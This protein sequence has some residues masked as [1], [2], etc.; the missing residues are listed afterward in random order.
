MRTPVAS[1]CC[2]LKREAQRLRGRRAVTE[3]DA[4]EG[5]GPHVGRRHVSDAVVVEGQLR[6]VRQGQETI[7]PVVQLR[8]V[9]TQRRYLELRARKDGIPVCH[10]DGGTAAHLPGAAVHLLALL[11]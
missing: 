9:Q 10:C 8:V 7:R 6:Q 11:K 2:A 4:L 5:F 1:L 3:R